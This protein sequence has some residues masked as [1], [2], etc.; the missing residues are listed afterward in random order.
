MDFSRLVLD[1]VYF[2][3]LYYAVF[4]LLTFFSEKEVKIRRKEISYTD[5]SIIIPMYNEAENIVC[6]IE[7]ICNVDYDKEKIKLIVVDD[8]STDNSYDLAKEAIKSMKERYPNLNALLLRQENAGK[9]KAMNYALEHVNTEFFATL[10]ADSYPKSDSLKI[11]LNEFSSKN[12]ASVTPILKVYNPTTIIE[13]IQAIEYSVNHFYKAVLSKANAIHVTPG[14]LAVYR[15]EVVKSL[16]GFRQGHKTEDMELA[17]RIQK[18]QYKIVQANDAIVYTKC[19]KT[20][21][22]LFAQRKRWNLG[23][24]RNILDY[25]TIMFNKKYGDF[26]LFQ[27]P[28]ILMSGILSVSI[29]SLLI[30]QRRSAIRRGYLSLKAYNFNIIEYIIDSFGTLNFEYWFFN[31]ELRSIIMFG[32]FF[33]ITLF[34]VY[35]SLSL[36]KINFNFEKF[37]GTAVSF[38]LFTFFYYVFLSTVW[39]VVFKD[40][41][42][43]KDVVW[44]KSI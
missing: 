32:F 24:I 2:I 6:T 37:K 25:K 41:F 9:Y 15:T 11:I 40:F 19:P 1:I 13:K 10:D 27:F 26:G 43:G 22:S 18:S 33:A 7:N 12:I 16:G 30:F 38:L 34:I 20:L 36:N 21:K 29:L 17:V 3:S 39:M 14:P 35:K 23:T 44:K 4:W 31:L 5:I 42:L 28:M 8:G